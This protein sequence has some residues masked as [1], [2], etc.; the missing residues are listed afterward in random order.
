[1]KEDANSNRRAIEVLNAPK[2]KILDKSEYLLCVRFPNG[3]FVCYSIAGQSH[4][5]FN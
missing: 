1:M 3:L 2:V 4:G 5:I